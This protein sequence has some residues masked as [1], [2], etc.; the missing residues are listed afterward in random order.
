MGKNVLPLLATMA[1]SSPIDDAIQRKMCE[2]ELIR[3]GKGITL[4]ISSEYINV[5]IVTKS[6]ENLGVI[7]DGVNETLKHEIKKW[8]G[9]FLGMLLGT[10]GAS[11]LGNML[12]GKRVMRARKDVMGAG[13]GYNK[14]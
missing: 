1:S 8:E 3:T 5:I 7:I 4:V 6:L 13:K 11:V 10:V 2:W 12:T 14:E 9:G